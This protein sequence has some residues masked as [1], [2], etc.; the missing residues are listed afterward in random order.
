MA[1]FH[2]LTVKKYL[3]FTHLTISHLLTIENL[4]LFGLFLDLFFISFGNFFGTKYFPG[5]GAAREVF[6]SSGGF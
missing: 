5:Q 2:V 1:V 6:G 4:V 3:S